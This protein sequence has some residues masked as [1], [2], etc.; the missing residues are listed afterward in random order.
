MCLESL[1]YNSIHLERDPGTKFSYSGAGFLAIEHLIEAM[2]GKRITEITRDFLDA[3]DL[4][5]SDFSFN[6]QPHVDGVK[7]AYGHL[8][9][10]EELPDGGRLA[11]PAFGAGGVCTPS[12]LARF[13]IHLS[14]AYSD[15]AGSGGVSHATAKALLAEEN[16]QDLGS[17]SF[18]R[19]LVGLGIFVCRAGDNRLMLHLGANDGFRSVYFLCFEGPDRGKGLVIFTN[20]DHAA[21]PCQAE[22]CR[23]LMGPDGI[24]MGGVDFAS[25]PPASEFDMKGMRIEHVVTIALVDLVMKGFQ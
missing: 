3:C 10:N 1:R 9:N 21:S 15:P 23:W 24:N 20:G 13:L 6:C 12:A 18:I 5:E 8:A 2:E 25:L 7:Y 4:P 14:K 11:F 17:V 16:L 19:S 22:V